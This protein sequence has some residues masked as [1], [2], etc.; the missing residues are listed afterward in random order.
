M[1]SSTRSQPAS[2]HRQ[3]TRCSTSEPAR[4]TAI[5]ELHSLVAAAC[6]VQDQPQFR[7]SRAGELHRVVLDPT[8]LRRESEWVPRTELDAGLGMT[9]DWIGSDLARTGSAPHGLVFNEGN[10]SA[11]SPDASAPSRRV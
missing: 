7:S 8:A 3:T 5:R 2:T 10:S 1:M 4:E 9:I 11:S 6:R